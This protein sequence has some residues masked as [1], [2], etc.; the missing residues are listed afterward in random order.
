MGQRP[1]DRRGFVKRAAGAGAL[2]L[3]ARPE[4]APAA[5]PGPP[6]PREIQEK[7][8]SAGQLD[9][10]AFSLEK[11]DETPQTLAF[12]ARDRQAAEAWQPR[13]REKLMELLGGFPSERSPLQARVVDMVE[14]PHYRRETVLFQSRPNLTVYAYFLMPIGPQSKPLPTVICLPGH[15]RGVDSICG[16]DEHGALRDWG[17]WGEYQADF[18][19][20][21]VSQGYAVLAMEPL[22][23]GY[24]RDAASRARNLGTSSCQPASGAALLFGETIP[25]WRVYDVMR[26]IDYLSERPEADSQRLAVMG[27]SGGGTITF[28][29]AALD[30][31]V[32]VAVVSGYYNTFRDS[33]VSITH[34]MDNYVPGLLRYAEMW[35]IA[36]LIAPRAFFV[37][38]G[39]KDDIFPIA[40][41][42]LAFGKAQEIFRVFGASERLDLEVF[43]GEHQFWGK[44]AFQFLKKQL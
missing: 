6:G 39:T 13:L 3:A 25:G 14:T 15:G 33:V 26:A 10:L 43:E 12:K 4:L 18:A 41:T 22:G 42:R 7:M 23:F 35:D 34:C 8:L 37:E 27:I 16:M 24:R 28:L 2:A 11:Y 21:S 36:G 32:K 44:G 38:S 40:A 31:R 19:L 17:Q 5:Q 9:T 1:I 29:T 20:Q 30:S